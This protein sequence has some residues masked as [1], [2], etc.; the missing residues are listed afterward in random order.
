MEMRELSE[1][2]ERR[3]DSVKYA[4]NAVRESYMRRQIVEAI[5]AGHDPERIVVVCGLT[6]PRPFAICPAR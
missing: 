2:K 6:M 5:A 1:E 4:Y 3:E